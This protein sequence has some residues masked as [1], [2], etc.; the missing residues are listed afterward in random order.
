MN[1]VG[2]QDTIQHFAT[3]IVARI[4]TSVQETTKTKNKKDG[5]KWP[6]FILRHFSLPPSLSGIVGLEKA[7]LRFNSLRHT[8]FT[9]LLI[10]S[11]I[12]ESDRLI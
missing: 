11:S 7:F 2:K 12:C 3:V 5:Q 9:I 8:M 1:F 6:P 10:A 4:R